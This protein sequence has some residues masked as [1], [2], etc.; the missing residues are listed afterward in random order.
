M[1]VIELDS[2]NASLSLTL[3]LPIKRVTT[4]PAAPAPRQ[5]FLCLGEVGRWRRIL[6]CCFSLAV[7][8]LI[9][10]LA[11]WGSRHCHLRIPGKRSE[12]VN[13]LIFFSPPCWF[14][15]S[16]CFQALHLVWPDTLGPSSPLLKE[17]KATNGIYH[18]PKAD[19]SAFNSSFLR[20][21]QSVQP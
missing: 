5:Q 19:C 8:P 12:S 9:P 1:Q 11:G 15:W 13:E 14:M 3:E 10:Q 7:S 21:A 2:L 16:G 17:L 4:L 20:Q 6:P 18:L